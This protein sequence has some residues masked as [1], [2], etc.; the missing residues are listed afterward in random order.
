MKVNKKYFEL[1]DELNNAKTIESHEKLFWQLSAWVDGVQCAGG[2]IS[3]LMANQYYIDQGIE[4]PM[5]DG[6]WIDWSES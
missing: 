5:W 3:G 4:R 2:F 1:L 6:V